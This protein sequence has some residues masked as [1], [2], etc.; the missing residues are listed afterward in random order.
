MA[1]DDLPY[2]YAERLLPYFT[3][4]HIQDYWA[5]LGK[6]VSTFSLVEVNMQLALWTFAGMSKTMARALLSGS[7]RIDAAMNLISKL[8]EA[9]Q[10]EAARQTEL[11]YLFTQLGII[12]KVRNDLLHYG[13]RSQ[14][15]GEWLVTSELLA[16]TKNQIRTTKIT[17]P[18]LEEMTRDITIINLR[19]TLLAWGDQMDKAARYLFEQSKLGAWHYKSQQPVDAGRRSHKI[20]RKHKRQRSPSQG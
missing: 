1:E 19:L 20:P 5:A 18:I 8:A 4:Q 12:N 9:Q 10:W 16:T 15:S 17:I 11:S 6:F 2:D 14:G 3:Q 7:T 13:A